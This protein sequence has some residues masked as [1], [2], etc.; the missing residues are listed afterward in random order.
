NHVPHH[1]SD[2]NHRQCSSAFCAEVSVP[3]VP[4]VTPSQVLFTQATAAGHSELNLHMRM[5]PHIAGAKHSRVPVVGT[6]QHR[7]PVLQSVRRS[8]YQWSL[9][10]GQTPGPNGMQS[11][12]PSPAG[13]GELQQYVSFA[14]PGGVDGHDGQSEPTPMSHRTTCVVAPLP[15]IGASM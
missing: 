14:S 12:L 7:S 4:T 8:Q 5:S 11:P 10:T 2:R 15:E 3:H 6:L 9:V 13:I 1:L